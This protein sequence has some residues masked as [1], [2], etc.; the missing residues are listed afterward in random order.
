MKKLTL[1]CYN[2]GRK[3]K[4]QRF[5]GKFATLPFFDFNSC[6]IP[7]HNFIFN[8]CCSINSRIFIVISRTAPPEPIKFTFDESLVEDS[9]G[10]LS[11]NQLTVDNLTVEWLRTRLTDLEASIKEI[12][13][14]RTTCKCNQEKRSA[15]KCSHDTLMNGKSSNNEINNR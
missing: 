1:P 6:C 2:Q 4:N 15:C 7:W 8:H 11:P 10:K 12:Q 3:T 5:L 9:A 14:K 13:E